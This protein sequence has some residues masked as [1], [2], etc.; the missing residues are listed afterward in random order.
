MNDVAF[1]LLA[2]FKILPVRI[3]DDPAHVPIINLL[4]RVV[5]LPLRR[6]TVVGVQDG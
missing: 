1:V 3:R 5:K 4:N 6:V 2:A